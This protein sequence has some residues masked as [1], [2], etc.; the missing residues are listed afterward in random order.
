[1]TCVQ[2]PPPRY[3]WK[4]SLQECQRPL[5]IRSKVL[6]QTAAAR[7]RLRVCTPLPSSFRGLLRLLI[8]GL[9]R[10]LRRDSTRIQRVQYL[11]YAVFRRKAFRSGPSKPVGTWK[12]ASACTTAPDSTSRRP[13]HI[14]VIHAAIS[15]R[16]C[17]EDDP[18]SAPANVAGV[19]GVPS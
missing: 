2:A 14:Q 11:T 5:F 15:N 13:C 8:L 1:M 17:T 9:I 3:H 7:R 12:D 16:W 4:L 10:H 18:G 6:L 19:A